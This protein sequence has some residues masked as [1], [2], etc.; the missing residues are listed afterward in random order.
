M[1]KNI[2]KDTVDFVENYDGSELEPT[3]LP[4]L[5]PNLLANGTSGIAVGMATNI[6]PHNL[7]ELID[8]ILLIAKDKDVSLQEIREKLKG[9]DFPTRAEIVGDTGILSYFETGRG[10]ITIRSKVKISRKDNGKSEIIVYEI[11]YQVNK[12]NLIEKIVDLVRH[13]LIQGIA[14]LRDESSREG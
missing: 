12:A 11:P 14:D 13:D 8:A 1:L 9:P 6:P 3:V 10:T 2:D 7:S 5:F 4:S